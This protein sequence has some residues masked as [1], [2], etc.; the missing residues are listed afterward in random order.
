MFGIGQLKR[1][2]PT[3][4][5]FEEAVTTAMALTFQ[6]LIATSP[7]VRLTPSAATV[8]AQLCT[9]S[10]I[11]RA[12][13]ARAKFHNQVNEQDMAIDIHVLQCYLMDLS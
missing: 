8:V 4:V 2:T 6:R 1:T 13:D 5:S 7:E 11:L 10:K 3:S 9:S 12:L